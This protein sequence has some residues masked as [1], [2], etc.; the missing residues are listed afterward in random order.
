MRPT[1]IVLYGPDHQIITSKSASPMSVLSSILV[2]NP[3]TLSLITKRGNVVLRRAVEIG[4]KSNLTYGLPKFAYLIFLRIL[5]QQD[6]LRVIA[7]SMNHCWLNAYCTS[8]KISPLSCHW[9]FDFGFPKTVKH[10]GLEPDL[11]C[12]RSLATQ[13]FQCSSPSMSLLSD[14]LLCRSF[15]SPLP[16]PAQVGEF[17]F[18]RIGDV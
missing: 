1:V 2:C 17:S 6:G 7:N 11:A 8:S 13:L 5:E 18:F 15:V 9:T 14:D 3:S 10:S 4:R 12:F 16:F